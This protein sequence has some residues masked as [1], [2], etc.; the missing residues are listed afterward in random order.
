M[1]SSGRSNRYQS[2]NTENQRIMKNRR[3]KIQ[4]KKIARDFTLPMNS[5]LA[6]I[7]EGVVIRLE[8][9]EHTR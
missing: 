9:N 1:S 5:D 2:E 4:K 8:K 7:R 6:S 3:K